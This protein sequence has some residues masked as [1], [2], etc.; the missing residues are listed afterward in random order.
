MTCAQSEQGLLVISNDSFLIGLLT[1][2]SAANNFSFRS[3][4][5]SEPLTLNRVNQICRLIFFDQRSLAPLLTASHFQTLEQIKNQY[6]IPICTICSQNEQGVSPNLPWVNY[7][8]DDNLIDH[9][10]RYITKLIFRT[11]TLYNERRNIERRALIDRRGVPTTLQTTFNKSVN[12]A[13]YQSRENEELDYLGPFTVDKNSFTVYCK[14]QNLLLTVK[15][16]KLFMLLAEAHDHVCSTETIIAQLWPNTPRAN[17]SDLYQYMHLLRKKVE[18]EP[19]N[20]RWI[21]TVKGV[22]YRLNTNELVNS[23]MGA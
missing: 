14:T 5:S 2:Y 20:P 4:S 6:G 10:D 23:A 7:L 15:E 1:G 19:N 3:I 22:G 16:F 17:K 18:D 11:S 9:L 8:F 13:N 12:T 21:L